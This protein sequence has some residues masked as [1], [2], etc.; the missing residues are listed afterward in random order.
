MHL[1]KFSDYAFRGLILAASRGGD[2]VTIEETA[3]TF[4]ISQGHLKKVVLA[5][6]RAGYLRGVK[7]RSGGYMLA[8][9][10]QDINL[11]EVLRTTETDF[12]IFKCFQDGSACV[13]LGPCRLSV[14]GHKAARAFLAAF[15]AVTLADVLCP[16]PHSTFCPQN[17]PPALLKHTALWHCAGLSQ[18]VAFG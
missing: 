5:M 17:K 16:N 18:S 11:G 3:T 10:P 13:N 6:T 1:T 4:G 2:L 14:I 15:D 9:K 8:R 7:G 12:G